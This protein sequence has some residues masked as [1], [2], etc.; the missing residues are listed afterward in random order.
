MKK[1][2]L[3]ALFSLLASMAFSQDAFSE[4]PLS[5]TD[6]QGEVVFIRCTGFAG[7]GIRYKAFLDDELACKIRNNRVVARKV[8]AGEHVFSVQAYGK[9]KKAKIAD[10]RIQVGPGE[11]K[12]VFLVQRNGYLHNFLCPVEISEDSAMLLLKKMHK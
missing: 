1:S 7:S 12:Y 2:G 3:L 6:A 9:K 4:K 11:R 10:T 5:A 8:A